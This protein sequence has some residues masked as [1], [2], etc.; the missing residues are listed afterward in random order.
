M[1]LTKLYDRVIIFNSFTSYFEML[2][3]QNQIHIM[4]HKFIHI[5][6]ILIRL[7]QNATQM[8]R[9]TIKRNIPPS[10]CIQHC[11]HGI[12]QRGYPTEHPIGDM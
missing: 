2:T 6:C 9:R 1:F 12:A 11:T 10:S 4:I 3:N 5:S 7:Q 8:L